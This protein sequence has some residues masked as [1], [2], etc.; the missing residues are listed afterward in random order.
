M[1]GTVEYILKCGL[2]QYKLVL[3]AADIVVETAVVGKR[4]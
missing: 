3:M 1:I 2:F 4:L